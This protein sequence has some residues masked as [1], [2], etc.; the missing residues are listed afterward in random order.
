MLVHYVTRQLLT[1]SR[2][3]IWITSLTVDVLFPILTKKL[4]VNIF[5][6]GFAIT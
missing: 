3:F 5:N 4:V 6:R 1:V 2:E